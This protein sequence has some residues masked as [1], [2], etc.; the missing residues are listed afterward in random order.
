MTI[1]DKQQAHSRDVFGLKVLKN[2]HP[3]LRKLKRENMSA[4]IH[5]N[6]FWKSTNV[7]IDYLNVA[8]PKKHW[9]ILEIGCGWGIAGIY[10]AKQFQSSVTG[11]D[12]DASVFPFLNHHAELNNV[13]V[14]PL[15]VPYEKVTKSMLGQFDMVI[16]SDICFWDDMGDLLFNLIN[17][18]HKAG[19]KRVVITDPGRPP[20]RKMAERCCEKFDAIYDNWSVPH[21]HN[22]SG[23]V[24]DIN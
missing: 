17:R 5:G 21:P 24:L 11:L 19:V 8:P 23:L 10:C 18:V 4:A 6:K 15:I 1:N 3:D 20:F 16:G 2:S 14:Q 9:R 22:T 13:V 7:M 12:A